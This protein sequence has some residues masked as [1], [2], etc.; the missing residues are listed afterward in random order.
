M[1][2]W[3][4]RWDARHRS[5]RPPENTA[6]ARDPRPHRS[7]HRHRPLRARR[8]SAVIPSRRRR[9][10][11]PGP[12]GFERDR[13]VAHAPRVPAI[14][15]AAGQR[16]G[17]L[18]GRDRRRPIGARAA[19]G[20][21]RAIDGSVGAGGPVATGAAQRTRSRLLACIG[22]DRCGPRH[23][24]RAALHHGPRRL[25][26]LRA[27]TREVMPDA[28]EQ[29]DLPDRVLAFGFGPPGGVR[30][31]G[32]AV[33][34]IPHTAHVNVQLADGALLDDP[35]RHRRGHRQAHSPREV[36]FGRGCCP[37]GAAWPPRG[38]G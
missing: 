5:T 19:T 12:G 6:H 38:P 29:V 2:P 15:D 13:A 3:P 33:G 36:P 4:Q 37:A 14:A 8:A 27:L 23:P 22:H 16:G 10:H 9:Q 28:Q 11:E 26:A 30:M 31:R 7:R 24:P 18:A 25:R 17:G 32:L 20:E 34:L 21:S 35:S 1:A